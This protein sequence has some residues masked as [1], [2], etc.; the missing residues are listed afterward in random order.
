MNIVYKE[1]FLIFGTYIAG[2]SLGYAICY[3]HYRLNRKPPCNHETSNKD[4]TTR[5]SRVYRDT[6]GEHERARDTS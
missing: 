3:Y 6:G 1:V 2:I 5:T 4:I